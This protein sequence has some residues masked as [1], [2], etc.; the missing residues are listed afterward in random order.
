MLGETTKAL[1]VAAGHE[2][3]IHHLVGDAS[4]V[5]TELG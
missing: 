5:R 1:S 4:K 2:A 3:E